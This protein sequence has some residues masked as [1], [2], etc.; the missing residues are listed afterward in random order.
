[1][2]LKTIIILTLTIF[3]IIL[4]GCV[5][6][7][8]LQGPF[9][10]GQSDWNTY[11]GNIFRNNNSTSKLKFPLD[12]LW[13]YSGSAGISSQSPLIVD[14][15]VFVDFLNGELNAINIEN[16]VKVGNLNIRSAAVG[17]P[18]IDG[19][20]LYIPISYNEYALRC[21][22][23]LDGQTEWEYKG[24]GI[25]S[26]LL[27]VK[28][29]LFCTTLDGK[30]LCV[31]KLTG[32]IVWEYQ[33]SKSIHSSPASDSARIITGCDDGFVYA[34]DIKEG[35][36]LWKYYTGG[37]IFSTPLISDGKVY[38]GSDDNNFYCLNIENGLSTWTYNAESPIKAGSSISDSV[39]FFASLKGEIHALNKEN[40]RTLWDFQAGGIVKTAPTITGD[41]LLFS[42]FDQKV[43]A[44]NKK[45]GQKVWEYEADG[46]VITSPITWRDYLI[47][48]FE[49]YYV[50]AFRSGGISK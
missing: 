30:I 16:G 26:S 36:L 8:K 46:R 20:R 22:D 11:G 9:W 41:Y 4:S 23:V 5:S 48:C 47:I 18:V 40:G 37:P 44:L 2:K 50:A 35:T 28:D 31:N 38:I 32:N 33:A 24:Q 43:Y 14:G 3:T 17:C 49:N 34:L 21:Y 12:F 39:I 6:Q 7:I 13:K 42:C 10:K 29:N 27:I 25:E 45:D 1:M 15:V 19:S